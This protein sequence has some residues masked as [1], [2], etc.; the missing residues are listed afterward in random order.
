M[1]R[2]IIFIPCIILFLF[3]CAVVDEDNDL[4]TVQNI[5]ASENEE[6]LENVVNGDSGDYEQIYNMLNWD[7]LQ[8]NM[9]SPWP[10]EISGNNEDIWHSD[11]DAEI[12]EIEYEGTFPKELVN[13]LGNILMENSMQ[14]KQ[15]MAENSDYLDLLEKYGGYEYKTALEDENDNFL[16]CFKY[17]VNEKEYFLTIY[18]S[19]G[20]AG[21]CYAVLS[22]NIRGEMEAIASF[23]MQNKGRGQVICYEDDYYYVYLFYNDNLKYYDGIYLYR[24]GPDVAEDNLYIHCIPQEYLWDSQVD[25]EDYDKNEITDCIEE[26]KGTL[27][28]GNY[29]EVGQDANWLLQIEDDSKQVEDFPLSNG[30]EKYY[31]ID[32]ANIGIP[33]YFQRTIFMPSNYYSTVHMEGQF[34]LYDDNRRK[35]MELST[36]NFSESENQLVQM[37]FREINNKIYTFQIY[38][39]KGYYY[40][41]SVRYIEGDHMTV[42]R[43]DVMIPQFCFE[44]IEG[45]K[46]IAF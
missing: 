22:E 38:H 32:F 31:M 16:N 23:D 35:E 29:I 15:S 21:F 3:G 40:L 13:E 17:N 44:I 39:L 34:Y 6:T 20:S 14:E 30:D 41:L 18:D 8:E 43:Q 27:L 9:F 5:T 4:G 10:D 1:W 45:K 7:K 11:I 19:G 37:W 36:L 12:V 28:S 33:V 42:V 2:V 46:W 25:K 24:L 26:I